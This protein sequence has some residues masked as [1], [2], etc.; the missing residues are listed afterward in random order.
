MRMSTG[1]VLLGLL[2]CSGIASAQ[3][4]RASLEGIAKDNT[5][6]VLP[7]VTVE[8]KNLAKGNVTSA[9]TD[10]LG[11]FRF[12]TLAPGSY[13]V[14][15]SLAS[16]S[17]AK[18]DRIDLA[19][20]EIKR[21]ELTL[22]VSGVAENVQVTAEQPLIDVK[23]TQRSFT[24]TA[25]Q[26]ERL[27]KG[28]DFT[29]V[30]VQAPGVNREPKSGGPTIDGSSASENRYIIDGVETTNPQNGTQGKFMVTDFISDVQVKSSGYTAEFG[31]STG[32]VVNVV[33]RSGTNAFRG[34][35]LAY[36]TNQSLQG[37]VR[38]T[39]R[40]A[41]TDATKAELITYPKDDTSRF[42]PGFGVGGPMMRDR[43]WFF[44]A[45]VP[46]LERTERTANLSNGTPTTKEQTDRT[47]N[48]SANA[49]AQVGQGQAARIA[50]NSSYRAIK[51]ILPAQN[52]SSSPATI[53]DTNDI[54]PNYSISGNY[55][56][57]V[58]D[59]FY[60]GAR[61]GY[62]HQN[63]YNENIPS[64]TRFIFDQTTNIGMPG[65]P[66]QFQQVSGF[67][68]FF[69]N[70]SI[71]ENSYGRGNLQADATYYANFAGQHTFKGG[72]QFD[73]IGNV[74]LDAEQSNSIRLKWNLDLGGVRGQFGHY[75]VRSNGP[76]PDLG[77]SV[78]G[79]IS[80][81]NVGLFFQDSW[82]V[83]NRLTL[84]L[85][86]R[87]EN[88]RVPSYTTADGVS[89]VAIKWGFGDKIAPRLGFA[90]DVKGDGRTK[91]F[92]NWGLYYDIFKLT[93]PRGAFGGD[94]WLEYYYTLDTPDYTSLDPAGC[95][96]ACPGTLIRGPV[97][98]RHPSNDAIDPN[99]KPMRLQEATA[100]VERELGRSMAVGIRYI[101]KQLDNS[102]EDV[103]SLDAQG[104]EIYVIGNPGKGIADTAFEG[105]PFPLAKRD[106]D[107]LELTFDK[108]YADRWSFRGSYTLSRLNGNYPG[109]SQSDENGRTD[110][111]VGRLFD[112]PL[113]AFDQNA[114]A[115]YGVLPTDRTHQ[116][117][118][119]GTYDL[120][121][122]TQVGLNQYIWSGIPITRE[123]S[124]IVGSNYPMQYAGRGSDGRT[125]ALSQTDLVA[126][127]DFRLGG[128]RAFRLQ[129]E[130][131]NLFDQA[132]AIDRYPTMLRAGALDFTEADFYAGRVNFEQLI[133]AQ[134]APDPR[135]LQ[136]RSFQD[137]RIIRF[138]AKFSF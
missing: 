94:K 1:A 27:P 97:D 45:Y 122:G 77:F 53:F 29:T 17:P 46:S 69:T 19:L 99:I 124:V 82:T 73:R 85:G 135:F 70:R 121:F 18:L 129:V 54:R 79:D 48:F 109:L 4:Q 106:Y 56:W 102:I 6:A 43:L 78:Q 126:G 98:F 103:G 108:R 57:T 47:Q 116:V 84:N 92:G 132:T 36:F 61:G 76:N 93:L 96:P 30:I 113:M 68:N 119:Q 26:F 9:V 25:E 74:V 41:P 22:T 100:G 10:E 11:A 81:T 62:Y 67:S 130:I 110:P 107:A 83:N 101:H 95:P 125:P 51:G 75:Q 118:F 137:P 5:G 71:A 114:Q 111:N 120:P 104:N 42:D 58:N 13:A 55:D 3:E 15:A 2:L 123:V 37:D 88:E 39:L 87:T 63:Q 32:G 127:H 28:R 91:V 133:A 24:V 138:G 65:V 21:V 136:N 44:A 40:L 59:R 52:G 131:L 117:K 128:R 72:V 112:Y 90:W 38:Q 80:N 66:A 14:T 23:Q 86:I 31:G 8:A 7:G 20:G 64:G 49:S 105:V 115:T 89:E 134:P 35:A 33:T 34:D 12:P 60:V 16:F 50:Y